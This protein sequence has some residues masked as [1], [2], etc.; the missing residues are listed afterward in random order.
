MKIA[1]VG[2]TGLVG[3]KMRKVLE[4]RGFGQCE[5]L[6]AASAKS[7]GKKVTFAGKECN[8]ISPGT[9]RMPTT[10]TARAPRASSTRV[11]APSRTASARAI[12]ATTRGR[13]T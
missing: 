2:A 1:L 11:A 9:G 13:V 12:R 8:V 4:E 6:P 7:V 5:F 10:G 3:S